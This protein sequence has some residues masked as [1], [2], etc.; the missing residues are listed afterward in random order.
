MLTMPETHPN[1]ATLERFDH[2]EA[3][4]DRRFDETLAAMK[5]GFAQAEARSLGTEVEMK[6]GFARVDERF[7]R[8]DA[9]FEGKFER[10]YQLVIKIGAG[11]IGTLVAAIVTVILTHL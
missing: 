8:M 9:K 7:E 4:T 10:L 2:L 1:Q 6:A 3:R 11:L 5:E